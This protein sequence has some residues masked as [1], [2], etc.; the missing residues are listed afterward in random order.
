M[1]DSLDNVFSLYPVVTSTTL[2]GSLEA[3]YQNCGHFATPLDRWIVHMVMAIVSL[4]KSTGREDFR[5]KEG[6]SYMSKALE[7]QDSVLRPGSVA[8]CQAVLLL[9]IYSL[10]DPTHFNCWYLIGVASRLLVDIGAHQQPP[11]LNAVKKSIYSEGGLQRRLFYCT[12]SMDRSVM[13]N[14]FGTPV[15]LMSLQTRKL[16]VGTSRLFFRRFGGHR[17][18]LV[19]ATHDRL[20]DGLDDKQAFGDSWRRLLN[21]CTFPTQ[22]VACVPSTL[23]LQSPK[24]VRAMASPGW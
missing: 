3:C 23:L 15:A 18:T 8:S 22:P 13:I 7:E 2:F 16:F 6:V 12:Y 24:S 10:L 19:D 17:T 9:A 21:A 14:L 11:T 20:W 5:Y 1:Q 4:C